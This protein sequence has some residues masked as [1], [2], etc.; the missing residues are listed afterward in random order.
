MELRHL[1]YFVAVAEELHFGRA[2][3][4]L[5]IS[6]PPLSQQIQKLEEELGVVLLERSRWHVALTP[7]GRRFYD[8]AQMILRS[9]NSAMAEAKR[10]HAG[11]LDHLVI[12][13]LSAVTLVGFPPFLRRFRARFPDVELTFLQLTVEQQ[14]EALI[15]GSIDAGF[16]NIPIDNVVDGS[17][18]YAEIRGDPVLGDHD[19]MAVV[20]DIHPLA[21]EQSISIARLADDNFISLPRQ[22]VRSYYDI[23]IGMC[24][25]AG[26]S[27]NIRYEVEQL[28]IALMLTAANYGVTFGPRFAARGINP[29]I[30]FLAL[31]EYEDVP[32]HLITRISDSSAPIQALREV[33]SITAR[34]YQ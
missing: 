26:F 8:R 32:I 30:R 16:I 29:H 5:H 7:A 34:P 20:S 18:R 11:E 10:I 31:E 2:A 3:K 22:K 33:T 14:L 27:P 28:P 9:S 13:F 12:G 25:K 21:S 1:R 4:R 17:N 19:L 6:Q 15:S 24:R 23:I